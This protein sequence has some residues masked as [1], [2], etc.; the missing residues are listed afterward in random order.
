MKHQYFGDINDYRKYGLLWCVAEATA[1]PLGVLWLLTEDDERSDGEFR[2]YLQEPKKWRHHDPQLYD[3][4]SKLLQNDHVRHVSHAAA[5]ELL[6]GATY[7]E[8]VF[9]DSATDRTRAME[10]AAEHLSRCPIIFIDPDNGIEVGSVSFGAKGSRRYVYWQELKALFQRGHSLLI[11]QHYPRVTRATFHDQLATALR[12]NLGAR[13]AIYSTPNVAFVMAVQPQHEHLL[14]AIARLVEDRWQGQVQVYPAA[15]NAL[16][17]AAVTE[18]SAEESSR[19]FARFIE[20]VAFAADKHRN[21]RRKDAAA[22]PYI[23]HPIAL[24]RVLAIEGGVTNPDVLCAA[25]LHDTVEDT[26][27]TFEELE[28]KFGAKIAG[29]VREV[30]DDKLLDKHVRKQLQIDHAAALSTEAK[31]VK[32]AD[33]ISNLRDIVASPPHDWPAERKRE[34]FEWARNVAAGLRTTNARLEGAFDAI[35]A[36][37]I[38]T[39]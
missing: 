8:H 39:L 16:E 33:K 32:L 11:Y 29:I 17:P 4:L 38:R 15:Q 36:E 1:Q 6:P 7:F 14:P 37:G 10:K 31:L 12:E 24:A 22:S 19:L 23:N 2:R 30:T 13:T 25:I 9:T 5:W 26:E 34:Y 35:Y 18:A 20:S 21:Q 27:T 3:A 28:H